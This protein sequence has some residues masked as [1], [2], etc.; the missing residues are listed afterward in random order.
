MTSR[1]FNDISVAHGHQVLSITLIDELL[2]QVQREW[3]FCVINGK[4]YVFVLM[5][6]PSSTEKYKY[7]G[8][9]SLGLASAT[10][11]C[12]WLDW[13]HIAVVISDKPHL[14]NVIAL[15]FW[16][17]QL[18]IMICL[19][20][21]LSWSS[22]HIW[23]VP[24]CVVF[25]PVCFVFSSRWIAVSFTC[26]MDWTIWLRQLSVCACK[27]VG[28]NHFFQVDILSWRS[29]YHKHPRKE[30]RCCHQRQ[31][32]SPSSRLISFADVVQHI[33]VFFFKITYRLIILQI[34]PLRIACVG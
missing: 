2:S 31:V 29:C 14:Y 6:V 3:I 23:V 19:G 30:W 32:F 22:S 34:Y 18:N 10:F 27:L 7:I 25:T 5:Q 13:G 1:V 24:F 21:C 8:S 20:I 26:N 15:S 16:F 9:R 17:D 4:K 33:W 12:C 28:T 11:P